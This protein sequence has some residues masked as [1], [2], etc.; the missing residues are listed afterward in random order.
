MPKAPPD[1]AGVGAVVLGASGFI[2]RW[3]A[4]ALG[5]AGARLHLVVRDPTAAAPVFRRWGVRGEIVCADLARPGELA[6]V[7]GAIRP[8]ITFNLA[9]YG[10]DRDERDV[11]LAERINAALVEELIDAVAA[12][13]DPS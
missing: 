7:L 10:V 4:R 8:S 6:A 3:V 2:G 1:Y 13:R 5:A 12:A 9:G 11:A